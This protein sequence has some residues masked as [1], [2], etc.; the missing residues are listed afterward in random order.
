MSLDACLPALV[1]SGDLTQEQADRMREIY[2]AQMADLSGKVSPEAAAAI[3]SEGTLKQ[4]S[5]EAA[6]KKRQAL[7]QVSKQAAI[8]RRVERF[9]GYDGRKGKAFVAVLGPDDNDPEKA[10][11][12][13]TLQDTIH[14]QALGLMNGVLHKFSRNLAGRVRNR[15][16]LQNVVREAFGEDTGDVAA[17]E[18]AKAWTDTAEMLRTRFNEA[19]GGI[20][21]LEHW[22][23]PQTHNYQAVRSTSFEDWR[24]FIRPLLDPEKMRDTTTGLPM[25]A[26]ALE[27]SLRNV[28]DQISSD[29][30]AFRKPGSTAGIVGKLANRH[31]DSRFLVFKD[32]DSWM[33]YSRRFG[34]PQSEMAAAI[35]PEG[36]IFDAMMGH[37][38][39]M[40]RDI[41]QMEVLGPN[42]KATIR[43][44]QDTLE[45][46]AKTG[47]GNRYTDAEARKYSGQ[48][49]DVFAEI[50]GTGRAPIDSKIGTFFGAVRAWQT[51]SKLGSATVS[52]TTDMG[53]QAVTRRFNGLPV[54]G[55]MNG[56]L[57]QFNPASAADREIAARIGFGAAGAAHSAVAQS[58]FAGEVLTGEM[59]SRLAE[60][61]LRASGL[62]AWTEAGKAAFG[63][64]F[65]GHVTSVSTQKWESLN[66]RFRN[67]LARYG[68]SPT[69]WDEL[70]STPIEEVGGAHWILPA[71][72]EN[73]DLRERLLG[74][75]LTETNY[76]V[77]ETDI[78]TRAMFNQHLPPKGTLWGEII[79]SPLQFKSFGV[80]MLMTHGRRAIGMQTYNGLKYGAALAISTT[81][82]GAL[83]IQMKALLRGEDPQPMADEKHGT[84]PTF[85]GQAMFQGG[86][87]GLAGDFLSNATDKY[88]QSLPSYLLGPAFS[89]ATQFI[90]TG[91]HAVAAAQGKP[92]RLGKDLTRIIQSDLPGSSLWY[93]KLA[94]NRTVLDQM[95]SQIDPTY[96]DSFGRME[97]RARQQGQ[98]Y[99][100]RPGETAPARG[101]DMQ[102]VLEDA[103]Q[104]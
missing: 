6:Q 15:A 90:K 17:K 62:S 8:L 42:P 60:G 99:W 35:D 40:S 104:H 43:W 51:A 93:A 49:A 79:R 84:D 52:A 25:T 72:I 22:G 44:M 13:S 12:V 48:L 34:R 11:S 96:Y 101:P 86:G 89:D 20:G 74:M 2:D 18:L 28:Y 68:F 31:A 26:Q 83:V 81:L 27:A 91:K 9:K 47:P 80:S 67:A 98:D 32:A 78:R 69:M 88:D 41:A 85:W 53:F 56:Y 3:A 38:S 94:F 50:S 59:A 29:G 21:K 61:V 33:E 82:M 54:V 45:R 36:P 4:I 14:T 76:A 39:S 66:P 57:R 7:L 100:W 102:N 55:A 30:W 19:G 71:N 95:Q 46:D 37:L 16:L 103:P 10:F 77:P 23:L 24:A 87:F 65:M 73:R 58:R 1:E 70:R 92:N 75:I 64:D 97:N 63:R 5:A